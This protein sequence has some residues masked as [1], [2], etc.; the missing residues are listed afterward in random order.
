MESLVQRRKGLLLKFSK[1]NTIFCLSLH[2]NT[3]NGYL[4]INRKEIYK[5]KTSNK[6]V[7]FPTQFYL[8]SICKGF[9]ATESREVP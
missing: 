1:G 8:G 9:S 5:F 6:N 7:T 4:F 2:C 3:E